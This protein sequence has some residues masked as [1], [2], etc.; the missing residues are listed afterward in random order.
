MIGRAFGD[1]GAVGIDGSKIFL[2]GCFFSAKNLAVESLLSGTRV[3]KEYTN[4]NCITMSPFQLFR[5]LY[6]FHG[7]FTSKGYTFI[8]F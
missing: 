3:G 8:K 4:G 5:L 2:V 7:Q 1:H 6:V